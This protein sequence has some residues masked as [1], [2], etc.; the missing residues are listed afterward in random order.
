MKKTL[1]SIAVVAASMV[2]NAQGTWK[3]TG[4]EA[5]IAA[6]TEI[7]LGV[8]NLKAAPS[9]HDAA[10]V[11]GKADSGAPTTTYN[12]V[13]YDNQAIV[14]GATNGMYFAF[15]AT[16]NG[17]LDIAVKMGSGK[18]TFVL[19]LKDEIYAS[20]SAT[21]GDI[22]ALTSSL[23]NFTD[24]PAANYTLPSVFDTYNNTTGTWNNSV[25]I[26]STGSNVYMV[27]SFPVKANKT[28]AI[29]V[30]GSKF[31]LRGAS[32]TAATN[33]GNIPASGFKVYP[34]PAN[35]KV[36]IDVNEPTNIGIYSLTGNLV[37]E[38]KVSSSQDYIDVSNLVAGMY[39]V[40]SV[41]NLSVAEKLLVN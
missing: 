26:Q 23:A 32:F 2:V 30:T 13:S 22:A 21:V 38:K 24:L 11:I 31:M 7:T 3:A 4:T 12:G 18:K 10:G 41:E 14:Q 20:I 5:S 40:K 37:V 34:N 8:P 29:G 9:D 19:E 27:M 33:V 35:G 39:F 17:T 16:K 15:L 28:Y 1:L 25:A 6:G 36:F